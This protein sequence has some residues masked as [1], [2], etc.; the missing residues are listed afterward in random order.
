MHLA[1]HPIARIHPP[2]VV[3]LNAKAVLL[4]VKKFSDVDVVSDL[5]FDRF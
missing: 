4:A 5:F 3:R 1:F 2:I